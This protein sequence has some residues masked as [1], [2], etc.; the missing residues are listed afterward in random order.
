[1]YDVTNR[2]IITCSL[3]SFCPAGGVL[4]CAENFV[5]YKAP[6]HPEVRAVIPRRTTLPADR[7]VLITS[8]A[9]HKQKNMFFVLLQVGGSGVGVGF[10][11]S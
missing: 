2:L 10:H 7:G 6:D 3:A 1:M 9:S 4:V 11:L 8:A 5:I